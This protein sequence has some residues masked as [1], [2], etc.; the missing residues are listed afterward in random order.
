MP[1]Q[2]TGD[3]KS[4]VARVVG[5]MVHERPLA[6]GDQRERFGAERVSA[7][8]GQWRGRRRMD[9]AFAG[10]LEAWHD[11]YSA[12][13]GV[14]ATLLG[15]LFVA[16][17]LNPRV[18]KTWQ[19]PVVRSKAALTFHNFLVVL[20]ISLVVL[21]PEQSP[22]GI[23]VSL[24]IVGI[25][26]LVRIVHDLRRLP[27]YDDQSWRQ[28]ARVAWIISLLVAYGVCLWVAIDLFLG[29]ADSFDWLVMAIFIL[30]TYAAASCFDLV[31]EIGAIDDQGGSP[32]AS[33]GHSA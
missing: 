10:Q 3:A 27:T 12:T 16:I 6:G 19:A 5:H 33:G 7:T 22:T 32:P 1:A 2:P 8:T 26:G 23:F 17:A 15:L 30:L 28:P 20:T 18:L 29:V 21:I 4:P 13:A 31:A 11:F 14:T 25:Q 24:A 9:T